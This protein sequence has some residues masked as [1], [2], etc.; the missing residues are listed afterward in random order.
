MDHFLHVSFRCREIPAACV[1]E[2][3]WPPKPIWVSLHLN[4]LI[5]K[6]G[7]LLLLLLTACFSGTARGQRFACVRGFELSDYI[8]VKVLRTEIS[9]LQGKSAWSLKM[10]SLK[11]QC[12]YDFCPKGLFPQL[13]LPRNWGSRSYMHMHHCSDG[14]CHLHDLWWPEPLSRLPQ[15]YKKGKG[16]AKTDE[17]VLQGVPCPGGMWPSPLEVFAKCVASLVPGTNR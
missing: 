1:R 12:Q 10:L 5:W 4:F 15:E 13:K 8:K 6:I 17:D 16:V 2:G 9:K 3:L 7:T 11:S 14:Q